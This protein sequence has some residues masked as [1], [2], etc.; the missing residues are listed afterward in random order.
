MA[1]AAQTGPTPEASGGGSAHAAVPARVLGSFDAT[2]VVIGAI[3]G[4]GIFISPTAVA[5]RTGAESL[6]LLGTREPQALCLQ[7]RPGAVV[8][9]QRDGPVLV[10]RQGWRGMSQPLS[11]AEA[12]QVWT[13]SRT[14]PNRSAA[15]RAS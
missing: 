14:M 9:A 12:R 6:A 15:T 11:A 4:V 5:E 3:I 1:S 10:W 2:C 8:L 13:P 7:L